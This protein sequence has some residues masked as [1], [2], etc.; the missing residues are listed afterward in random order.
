MSDKDNVR[1][2]EILS[3]ERVVEEYGHSFSG[4]YFQV[5]EYFGKTPHTLESNKFDIEKLISESRD[6]DIKFYQDKKEALKVYLKENAHSVLWRIF[7]RTL[8]K[9][10]KS[11][12]TGYDEN[13]VNVQEYKTKIILLDD[14]A[15]GV[16][17]NRLHEG[18]KVYIVDFFQKPLAPVFEVLE[19]KYADLSVVND[20]VVFH[21][22][23]T[24]E[25]AGQRWIVKNNR[26]TGELESD[27]E[28]RFVFRTIEEARTFIGSYIE[29]SC[30]FLR[31]AEAELLS[32][33]KDFE[34]N[35]N[36]ACT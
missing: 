29:K 14:T 8:L 20:K 12:I 6:K 32:Q 1:G 21:Y 24:P 22:F 31:V 26:K 34:K 3:K 19:V 15:Y 33:I 4:D 5:K 27:Y 35:E 30:H 16:P 28:N 13:I 25:K 7:N 36:K 17:K 11:M 18:D 10:I 2:H 9:S 23:L